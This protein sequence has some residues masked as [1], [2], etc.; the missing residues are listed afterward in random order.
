M[1]DI[2]K[3]V[4]ENE[5][6]A[7]FTLLTPE[8]GCLFDE[9]LPYLC[10]KY[11]EEETLPLECVIPILGN[12]PVISHT[13]DMDAMLEAADD[14]AKYAEQVKGIENFLRYESQHGHI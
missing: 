1:R 6:N 9:Y 5:R 10:H 12:P 2:K 4:T 7:I 8:E 13:H 3:I 14:K 11:E